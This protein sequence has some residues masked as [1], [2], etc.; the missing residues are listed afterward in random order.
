MQGNGREALAKEDKINL[1]AKGP[2]HLVGWG[3]GE[4]RPG[5]KKPINPGLGHGEK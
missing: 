3:R 4:A 5:S 1:I 2:N